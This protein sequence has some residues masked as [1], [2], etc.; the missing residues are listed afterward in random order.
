MPD[1]AAFDV[2]LTRGSHPAGMAE[3]GRQAWESRG[4]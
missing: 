4:R 1:D 2:D 3:G